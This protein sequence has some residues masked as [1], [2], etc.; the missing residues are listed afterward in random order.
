MRS[1][2]LFAA[3]L[4]G[5]CSVASREHRLPTAAPADSGELLCRAPAIEPASAALPDDPAP[6]HN[7]SLEQVAIAAT[8]SP[9][10][11]EHEWQDGKP[12]DLARDDSRCAG[13][14]VRE[15]LRI[16][17]F[18]PRVAGVS[19]LAG[20]REGTSVRLAGKFDGQSAASA[21]IVFPVRSGDR[22][23]F[24]VTSLSEA[25]EWGGGA[26]SISAMISESWVD[27]DRG[28]IVVVGP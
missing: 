7:E 23:V 17:C 26:Q 16:R 18:I 19:L 14:L 4:L 3:F 15:W 21:E 25:D 27:Q 13:R 2:I 22:R 12:V 24:Q 11:K 20:A 1:V 6:L 9:S 8:R 10:P 5:G 28:P